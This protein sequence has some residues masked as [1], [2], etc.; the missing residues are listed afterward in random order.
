MN[1]LDEI[2]ISIICY[3]SGVL[4][5]ISVYYKC[6]KNNES[7]NEVEKEKEKEFVTNSPLIVP[8]APAYPVPPMNPDIMNSTPTKKQII[9]T[10]E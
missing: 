8:S 4:T 10:T 5:G 1:T 7:I 6:Q 2:L 9:I 3:L